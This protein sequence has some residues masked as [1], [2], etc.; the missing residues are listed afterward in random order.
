MNPRPVV[1]FPDAGDAFIR[2]DFDQH[3]TGGVATGLSRYV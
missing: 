1:G 3:P 2:L